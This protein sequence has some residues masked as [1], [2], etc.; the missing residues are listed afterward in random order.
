MNIRKEFIVLSLLQLALLSCKEDDQLSI[1]EGV[2]VLPNVVTTDC[3]YPI[4]KIELPL[5]LTKPYNEPK[6]GL[7]AY[8]E[9]VKKVFRYPYGRTD[10]EGKVYIGL[11]ID[12]LGIVSNY[13][14]IKGIDSLIDY[15]VIEAIKEVNVEFSPFISSTGEKKISQMIIPVDIN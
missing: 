7:Q 11:Q 6:I 5:D 8:V 10:Y 12:T 15:R 13:Q 9:M 1:K 3:S 14:V 2:V 4:E